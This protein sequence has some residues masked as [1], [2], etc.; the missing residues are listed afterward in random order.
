MAMLMC[1]VDVMPHPKICTPFKSEGRIRG[2]LS[3]RLYASMLCPQ[4]SR[5]SGELCPGMARTLPPHPPYD[6]LCTDT[7]YLPGPNRYNF[8]RLFSTFNLALAFPDLILP[9]PKFVVEARVPPV[10]KEKWKHTSYQSQTRCS[11][12]TAEAI[13]SQ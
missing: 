7:V 5:E 13:K 2:K 1:E 4:T 10:M 6:N 12:A 11:A 9:Q 8:F 3:V